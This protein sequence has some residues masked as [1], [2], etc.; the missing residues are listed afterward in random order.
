MAQKRHAAADALESLPDPATRHL[1]REAVRSSKLQI[2][3]RNDLDQAFH[4]I[5]SRRREADLSHERACTG[6]AL[7]L[8]VTPAHTSAVRPSSSHVR[9]FLGTQRA[10]ITALLMMDLVA[11]SWFEGLWILG[12]PSLLPD[13]KSFV[14]A[15][16]SLCD[17]QCTADAQW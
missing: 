6:D 3:N 10:P 15:V 1:L 11:E 7:R 4:D 5:L 16:K 12:Q 9:A 17:V 2:I 8:A 14:C 13:V